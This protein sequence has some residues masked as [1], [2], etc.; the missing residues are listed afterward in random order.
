MRP[1]NLD[2]LAMHE[3]ARVLGGRCPLCRARQT[4]CSCGG[5]CAGCRGAAQF[6]VAGFEATSRR[7]P[8]AARPGRRPPV[9]PQWSPAVTLKQL[10]TD[11]RTA[12]GRALPPHILR[13]F[14]QPG[15]RLY[16]ITVRRPGKP[17]YRSIGR[18]AQSIANR[19]RQHYRPGNKTPA[20]LRLHNAMRRVSRSRVFIQVAN[21]PHNISNRLAHCR[22]ILRQHGGNVSDWRIIRNTTTFEEV[23]EAANDA[24]SDLQGVG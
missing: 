18:T 24:F 4:G 8:A 3:E 20:E 7:R 14:F 1:N 22:E 15:Q 2:H 19:I 5:T 9:S 12:A 16:R 17:P 10:L 11:R 6:E 13:Q 23:H 21:L